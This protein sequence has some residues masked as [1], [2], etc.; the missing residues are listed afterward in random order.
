M[1]SIDD[2]GNVADNSNGRSSGNECGSVQANSSAEDQSTTFDADLEQLLNSVPGP[3][4]FVQRVAARVTVNE[5]LNSYLNDISRVRALTADEEA[6]F[7][8]MLQAEG[9]KAKLAKKKLNEAYLRHVVWIAKEYTES[10]SIQILDLIN[11]GAL[12]LIQAVDTYSAEAS[13]PFSHHAAVCIKRSIAHALSEETRLSRVPAYLLD[14]VTSVKGVTHSLATE[15]GREPS[16][17]E[18]ADA[19]GLTAEELERLIQI[20]KQGPEKEEEAPEA[21]EDEQSH[22]SYES[23]YY[24]EYEES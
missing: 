12:G 23:E 10:G 6:A 1:S 20:V 4:D 9:Q 14:K 13:V 16:R 3:E 15:L 19:M 5:V 17:I 11:E 18:I 2:S 21:V 22:D 24:E 8:E 7:L